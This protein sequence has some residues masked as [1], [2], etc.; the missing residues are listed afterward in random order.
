MTT[1]KRSTA[2][3]VLSPAESAKRKTQRKNQV[4]RYYQKHRELGLCRYCAEKVEPGTGMCIKHLH[5]AQ[6]RKDV[7]RET[8]RCPKCSR[9]VPQEPGYEA[10]YCPYCRDTAIQSKLLWRAGW[11]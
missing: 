11:N 9:P 7:Y 2:G 6:K 10:V 5:C 8:G 4:Q 1:A 3:R